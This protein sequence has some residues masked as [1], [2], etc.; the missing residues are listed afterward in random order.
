MSSAFDDFVLSSSPTSISDISPFRRR[1]TLNQNDEDDVAT[2]LRPRPSPV[3][4]HSYDLDDP[5][6]RERQRTMDVDMAINL[7]RVRRESMSVAPSTSPFDLQHERPF[8]IT[9]P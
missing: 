6:V 5:E 2:S 7:S 1:E 4:V 3:I 9:S 8:G